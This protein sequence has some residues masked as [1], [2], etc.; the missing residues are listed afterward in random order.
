MENEEEDD[1]SRDDFV[2]CLLLFNIAFTLHVYDIATIKTG[3]AYHLNVGL[4]IS[5]IFAFFYTIAMERRRN[6]RK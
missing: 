5:S 4:F 2:F 6:R 1:T 3:L